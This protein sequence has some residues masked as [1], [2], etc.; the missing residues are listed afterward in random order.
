MKIILSLV[1]IAAAFFLFVVPTMIIL[2]NPITTERTVV[3]TPPAATPPVVVAPGSTDPVV[4]VKPVAEPVKIS[5]YYILQGIL[6][7]LLFWHLASRA[8]V[9]QNI[10]IAIALV[11]LAAGAAFW[12]STTVPGALLKQSVDSAAQCL[13][14]AECPSIP[15]APTPVGATWVGL[16]VLAIVVLALLSR[17][18]PGGAFSWPSASTMKVAGAV[19]LAV[20][21][22]LLAIKFLPVILPELEVHWPHWQTLG[23]EDSGKTGEQLWLWVH[24]GA[25]LIIFLFLLWLFS[26]FLIGPVLAII[27]TVFLAYGLTIYN[28]TAWG[29]HS[30][31]EFLQ[32][33]NCAA[34]G[35]CPSYTAVPN[36]L[37]YGLMRPITLAPGQE[38]GAVIDYQNTHLEWS[39]VDGPLFPAVYSLIGNEDTNKSIFNADADWR[40]GCQPKAWSFKFH[41]PTNRT[42]TIHVQRV[43]GYLRGRMAM[44][45]S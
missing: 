28:Q 30:L 4:V 35:S 45:C 27:I 14:Y 13:F 44:P 40:R 24:W 15:S 22:V 37:S 29:K 10:A 23:I 3:T 20:V 39:L 41:N 17:V 42:I 16:L 31:R 7:L 33:E 2:K 32:S 19:I 11:V 34:T 43:R 21:A 18:A 8:W 36:R 6:L 9:L 5:P 26:G 38:S 12:F 25:L 1:A